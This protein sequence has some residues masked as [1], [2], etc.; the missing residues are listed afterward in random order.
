MWAWR[1]C[2]PK[3]PSLDIPDPPID[4]VET[5]PAQFFLTRKLL[6]QDGKMIEGI[7]KAGEEL[8]VEKSWRISNIA[9]WRNGCG[10]RWRKRYGLCRGSRID[11]KDVLKPAVRA[12]RSIG[13]R[14]EQIVYTDASLVLISSVSQ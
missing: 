3:R 11:G 14:I 4:Q 2:L 5:G 9:H 1:H 12:T 6:I 10:I 8:E 13:A 7:V